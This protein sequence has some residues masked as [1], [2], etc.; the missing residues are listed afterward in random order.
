MVETGVKPVKKVT[1]SNG[2]S[3]KATDDHKVMVMRKKHESQDSYVIPTPTKVEDLVVGDK[4]QP[5]VAGV[6]WSGEEVFANSSQA[7]L[8]GLLQ[9]DGYQDHGRIAIT[10]NEEEVQEFLNQVF[11]DLEWKEGKTRL[12]VGVQETLEA[13]GLSFVPLPDRSVPKHFFGWSSRTTKLFLKGLYSA[14]GC[15]HVK[16]KRISLKT[17]CK[18]LAETLQKVLLALGFPAYITTN[19]SKDIEWGNGVYASKSPTT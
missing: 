16:D 6:D 17:T 2:L 18:D 13:R 7:I 15:L 9:G 8:A 12:P 3:F 14:N 1:L 19:E 10:T 4:M 11:T 5:F